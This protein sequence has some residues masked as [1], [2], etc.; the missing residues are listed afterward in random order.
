MAKKLS[1]DFG[2]DETFCLQRL[3]YFMNDEAAT[4]ANLSTVKEV[5]TA[6]GTDA[7]VDTSEDNVM[8]SKVVMSD[9]NPLRNIDDPSIVWDSAEYDNFNTF[10]DFERELMRII[11]K[12]NDV[13]ESA[14]STAKSTQLEYG[15]LL[16]ESA[17]EGPNAIATGGKCGRCLHEGEAQN[18]LVMSL[19]DESRGLPYC[20]LV[21]TSSMRLVNSIYGQKQ[22]VKSLSNFMSQLDMSLTI[23]R[24]R[25]IASRLLLD[26]NVNL[27]HDAG[28]HYHSPTHS[29]T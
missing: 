23:L 6:S 20:D 26:G 15:S 29:L 13:A 10:S 17:L 16:V 12:D 14:A 3:E 8:L 7:P 24:T 5:E 2:L 22:D 9:E 1:F 28:T 25:G 27:L 18:E 21:Q 19:Y 11:Y 4:R